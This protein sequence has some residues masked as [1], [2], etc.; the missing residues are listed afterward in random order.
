MVQLNRWS[1]RRFARDLQEHLAL[2]LKEAKQLFDDLL[3]GQPV[4]IQFE[5]SAKAEALVEAVELIGAATQIS[6]YQLS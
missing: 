3:A 5:E 6:D 1:A 4:S 2:T